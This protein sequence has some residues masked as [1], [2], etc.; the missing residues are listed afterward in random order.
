MEANGQNQVQNQIQSEV[1]AEAAGLPTPLEMELDSQKAI[2]RISAI[3]HVLDGCAKVSIQRTNPKDWVKMGDSFYIFFIF[4]ITIISQINYLVL[5]ISYE[6]S[7]T[8]FCL[9]YNNKLFTF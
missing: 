6:Q 3:A 8:F 9:Y 2:A 5:A 1:V 7:S 4:V